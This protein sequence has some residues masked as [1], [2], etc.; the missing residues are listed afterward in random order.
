MVH[1]KGIYWLNFRAGYIPGDSIRD[2]LDPQT[3]EVTEPSKKGHGYVFLSQVRRQNKLPGIFFER[4]PPETNI[5]PE[6]AWLECYFP[7]GKAHFQVLC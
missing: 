2:L 7:F 4:T 5:A 1:L 6:N 3:L